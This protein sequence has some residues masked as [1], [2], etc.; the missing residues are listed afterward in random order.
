MLIRALYNGNQ[1]HNPSLSNSYHPRAVCAAIQRLVAG[2]LSYFAAKESVTYAI[3]ERKKPQKRSSSLVR[4]DVAVR[5]PEADGM[6]A[7][8]AHL[9][10]TCEPHLGGRRC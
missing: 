9:H 5:V 10:P 8:E 3:F 7:H 2:A 1:E 4:I 6:T